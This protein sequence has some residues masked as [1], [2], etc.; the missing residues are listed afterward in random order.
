MDDRRLEDLPFAIPFQCQPET[1]SL[2]AGF[3]AVSE[4][5]NPC[6]FKKYLFAV[7]IIATANYS[8][9]NLGLLEQHDWL[10]NKDNRIV[11]H[12]QPGWFDVA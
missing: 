5:T 7:P 6:A 11:V 12:F 2:G 4:T 1:F 3:C 10:G 9:A 8:T